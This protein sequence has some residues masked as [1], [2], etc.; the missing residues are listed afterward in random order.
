MAIFGNGHKIVGAVII[1]MRHMMAQLG[2]KKMMSL[3]V[4]IERYVAVLGVISS[5]G[6]YAQPA[7]FGM[8]LRK[9]KVAWVFV[10]QGISDIWYLLSESFS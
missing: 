6:I 4:I 9:P 7:D 1:R 2:K 10:S 8:K 3:T 5:L